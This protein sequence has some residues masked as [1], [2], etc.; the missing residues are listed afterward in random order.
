MNKYIEQKKKDTSI[1]LSSAVRLDKSE[2]SCSTH[3]TIVDF[4]GAFVAANKMGTRK[5]NA[6]HLCIEADF[7]GV[8]SFE[9]FVL[10]SDLIF[11]ARRCE[12][13]RMVIVVRRFLQATNSGEKIAA[14][15]MNNT[16]FLALIEGTLDHGFRI[17]QSNESGDF[18]CA[19]ECFLFVLQPLLNERAVGKQASVFPQRRV[20]LDP[21]EDSSIA[22][23]TRY[24]INGSDVVESSFGQIGSLYG[25]FL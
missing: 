2:N 8:M 10:L 1:L 5:E 7:A 24:L 15:R 12:R 9:P 18:G 6:V 4:L 11:D 3:G 23:C 22:E 17:K 20:V 14:R 16:F 19:E 25:I 21:F 13:R